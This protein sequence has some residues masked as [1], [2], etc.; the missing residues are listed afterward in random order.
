MPGRGDEPAREVRSQV[1]ERVLQK[2]DQGLRNLRCSS[3]RKRELEC[4][5]GL[6]NM[7]VIDDL[8]RGSFD[9]LMRRSLG[10]ASVQ[11]FLVGDWRD[12]RRKWRK[13]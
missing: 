12:G 10:M 8:C 6:S 5:H 2:E 4:G 7:E 9:G 13:K 3:G 11:E 1:P